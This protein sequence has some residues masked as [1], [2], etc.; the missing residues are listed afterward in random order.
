[1]CISNVRTTKRTTRSAKSVLT[2]EFA[3]FVV[4][5]L[6]NQHLKAFLFLFLFGVSFFEMCYVSFVLILRLLMPTRTTPTPLLT[7]T[8][9]PT[10]TTATTTTTTTTTT[11]NS[12]LTTSP[13]VPAFSPCS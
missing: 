8:P 1:M 6:V 11:T 7:T 13:C 4:F 2:A 10:P 12:S 9:T 3:D 5:R